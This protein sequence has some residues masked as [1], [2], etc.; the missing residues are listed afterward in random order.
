LLYFVIAVVVV[1]LFNMI[2]GSVLSSTQI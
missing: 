1:I 2:A